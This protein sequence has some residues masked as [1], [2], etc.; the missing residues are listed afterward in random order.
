MPLSEGCKRAVM[1]L[2]GCP[3]CRGVPSLPPCRGFCL[4]VAYGCIGS[5]GL[6]PDW[7][8]YL[9]EGIQ[10]S[11]RWLSVWGGQGGLGREC[12]AVLSGEDE[13]GSSHV[14]PPPNLRSTAPLQGLGQDLWQHP[15]SVSISLDS[16]SFN[17]F[18]GLPSFK[19]VSCS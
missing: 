16:P 17:P 9:G 7:G 4:N 3:L 12:S 13:G 8:P 18:S 19:M 6:D 1:R 5:Q 15:T 14:S 11:L 10:E 2:T